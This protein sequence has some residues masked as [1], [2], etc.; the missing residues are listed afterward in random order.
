MIRKLAII[1]VCLLTTIC[2]A[3][4]NYSNSDWHFSFDLPDDWKET[5]PDDLSG[6][7]NEIAI[8]S[9]GQARTFSERYALVVSG[10]TTA[11]IDHEKV[12]DEI[13]NSEK[14][15]AIF[16]TKNASDEQTAFIICQAQNIGDPH[17]ATRTEISLEKMLRSNNHRKTC[18]DSLKKL[19]K[20][21]LKQEQ[22]DK[23]DRSKPATQI[24]YD[25]EKHVFYERTKITGQNDRIFIASRINILGSNMVTTLIAHSLNEDPEEFQDL[26]A[27]IVN[28]FTYD[29]KYG[30]GETSTKKTLGFFW[31][32]LASGIVMLILIAIACQQRTGAF[33]R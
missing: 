20:Q 26:L 2:F 13:L 29:T 10:N 15:V 12:A 8:A 16:Q 25:K 19:H 5:T 28:S 21:L 3:Q 9:F 22:G 11:Q 7:Y 4:Q 33:F 14:T 32:Y 31:A 24:F 23:W 6:K 27:Q 1:S 18:V 17:A 30:F